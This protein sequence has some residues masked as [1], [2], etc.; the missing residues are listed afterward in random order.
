MI[1]EGGNGLD[2]AVE[3]SFER[4]SWANK[5]VVSHK[6]WGGVGGIRRERK[7]LLVKYVLN[8]LN[9]NMTS[10]FT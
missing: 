1:S 9:G 7:S 10:M 5:S 2:D 8:L 3:D 4:L 6:G